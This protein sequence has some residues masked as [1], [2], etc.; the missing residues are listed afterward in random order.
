M[1]A[2]AVQTMKLREI[3][4]E[5]MRRKGVVLPKT[6][7]QLAYIPMYHASEPPFS[8]KS[9][10]RLSPTQSYSQ[11]VFPV[12]QQMFCVSYIKLGDT[13]FVIGLFTVPYTVTAVIV[14]LQYGYGPYIYGRILR[15]EDLL[16][17][18]CG[19][20]TAVYGNTADRQ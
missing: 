4:R 12:G 7:V 18:R 1:V 13:T 16:T 9:N 3:G 10:P 8:Q 2:Y 20:Y 6:E 15:L 14:R 17:V 11:T 5:N 19:T